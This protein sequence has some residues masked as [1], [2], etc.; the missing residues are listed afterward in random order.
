MKILLLDIET[1]PNLVHVWGLWNQNVGINQ[2]MAAGYVMCWAAKWHGSKEVMFDSVYA[3]TQK[4]MLKRI[5]KLLDEAD[6]VV[7]WN[8]AKFD[9]PTLNKE[10][11]SLEM[12]PPAPY[13]QIDLLKTARAQFK[14]PS[15]KLDYIG[16]ALGLGQKVKHSGH[17]LWIRCM[18][19]EPQAWKEMEAY[20]RQDVILLEKVYER[21]MPWVKNHPNHGVYDEA[22]IPV[23]PN[24]GHHHLQRRGKERTQCNVYARYQCTNCGKWSR[25]PITEM[26]R[27]DRLRIMR[28][29][30]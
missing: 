13:K 17:E 19:K 21:L 6:A 2:I 11:V 16:Q 27:E 18:A 30:A 9:I 14:F 24:C 7:H 5:H 10:F 20:N 8:G 25:E 4:R 15:N 26:P 29:V 22:G 23:C 1:A 12:T 28:P 3:S